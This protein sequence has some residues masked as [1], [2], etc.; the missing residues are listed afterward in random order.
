MGAKMYPRDGRF[1]EGVAV[2]IILKLSA[3][4]FVMRTRAKALEDP[5]L[6]LALYRV[7]TRDADRFPE[8]GWQYQKNVARGRTGILIAYLRSAARTNGWAKQNSARGAVLYGAL[9]RAGIYEEALH[10]LLKV[11]SDAINRLARS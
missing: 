3:I 8:L 9:L 4:A 7:V 11:D 5:R 6:K 1:C 10:G 2:A